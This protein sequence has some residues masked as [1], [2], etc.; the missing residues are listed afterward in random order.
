[1]VPAPMRPLPIQGAPNDRNL[2]TL[3]NNIH[4]EVHPDLPNW[5]DHVLTSSIPFMPSASG[6]GLFQVTK[7]NRRQVLPAAVSNLGLIPFY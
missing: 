3:H 5:T 7:Q 6:T 1:M 2:P 4:A